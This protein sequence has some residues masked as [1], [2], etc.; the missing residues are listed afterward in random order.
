MFSFF[1][2]F[3]GWNILLIQIFVY[4]EIFF[5]DINAIRIILIL[6]ALFNYALSGIALSVDNRNIYFW[7][8]VI[9]TS[10]S[11]VIVMLFYEDIA[12]LNQC[13]VP[14]VT[15]FSVSNII[16]SI[17]IKKLLILKRDIFTILNFVDCLFLYVSV[18]EKVIKLI[19][20]FLF[21]LV[22]KC[23]INV[24]YIYKNWDNGTTI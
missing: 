15:M 14:L 1:D 24:F 9:L 7:E 16:I 2:S 20:I 18:Y 12:K 13:I 6:V 17:L 3:F 22:I 8:S 21:F 4:I 11:V 19:S 5:E 10:F 23:V